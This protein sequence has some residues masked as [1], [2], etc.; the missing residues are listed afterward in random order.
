MAVDPTDPSAR[1]W[2]AWADDRLCLQGC[3]SCGR[4]QHPPSQVCAA[5]KSTDWD[6]CDITPEATLVSWSNVHRAPAPQFAD[7][8][9]YLIALVTVSEG[10]LLEA[11]VHTSLAMTEFRSG[12]P[13]QLAMG[14][15]AGRAM[16]IVISAG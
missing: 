6:L 4:L 1:V 12:M 15:V 14:A 10:T 8:V 3:R 9:P 13:V 5:C 2:Q 11:R 16:P 7:E